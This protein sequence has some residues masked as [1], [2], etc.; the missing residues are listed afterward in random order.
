MSSEKDYK[1]VWNNCL[2][3]IKDNVSEEMFRTWFEPIVPVSLKDSML[4]LRVGSQY[5]SDYLDT[6]FYDLIKRTIKKDSNE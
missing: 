6:H 1:T 3:V 4:T 5:Y 2:S